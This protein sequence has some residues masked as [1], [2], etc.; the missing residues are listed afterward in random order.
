MDKI[1]ITITV[2]NISHTLVGT[3]EELFNKDWNEDIQALI[4]QTNFEGF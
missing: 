2:D 3:Y 1:T 4:D